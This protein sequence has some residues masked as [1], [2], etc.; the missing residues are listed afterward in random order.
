MAKEQGKIGGA[1][2]DFLAEEG[3]LEE[4]RTQAIKEV[5]AM[6]IAQTMETENISKAAMARRMHTSRSALDRLLD[7]HN[8]A[9]TLITMQRAATA[10]GKRLELSLQDAQ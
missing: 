1:F 2:S 6:Q 8:T 10:L 7:P 4:T 5:L 3:I 9:V